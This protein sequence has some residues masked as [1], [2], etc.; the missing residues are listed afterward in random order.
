MQGARKGNH[1]PIASLVLG[2]CA[3]NVKGQREGVGATRTSLLS[4]DPTKL[5]LE[6]EDFL[7]Q[8]PSNPRRRGGKHGAG[9]EKNTLPAVF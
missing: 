6:E 7:A 8:L 3:G 4:A 5:G 1:W 9:E 2:L